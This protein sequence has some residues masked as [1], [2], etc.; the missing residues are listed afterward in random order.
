LIH[1]RVC[2]F[3]TDSKVHERPT[4]REPSTP[5][6]ALMR[7]ASRPVYRAPQPNEFD[8]MRASLKAGVK[9]SH[10]DQLVPTPA[11]LARRMAQLA[12]NLVGGRILDPSAGRGDLLRA[13][14]NATTGADCCRVVAV[15]VNSAQVEE[16]QQL[17]KTQLYTTDANFQIVHADFLTCGAELGLFDA[18]L[19]NPPFKDAQDIPHILH[20]LSMLKPGGVMVGICANGSRQQKKLLPRVKGSGG[21]WED[22]PVD[23]FRGVYVR[24]A[25]FTL[26]N[27]KADQ[28]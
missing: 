27:T 13:A 21:I 26:I 16:L 22:L 4:D 15:E 7:K 28:S 12:G 8:A 14:W 11:P 20:A 5:E 25:L 23:T 19:M 9:V 18:I 2:V 1:E 24:A 17:R 3:L 6:I 10:V